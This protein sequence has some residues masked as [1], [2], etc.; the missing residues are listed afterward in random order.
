MRGGSVDRDF[1]VL[2]CICPYFDLIWWWLYTDQ[3]IPG[4][5][6]LHGCIAS[7]YT[8]GLINALNHPLG[9]RE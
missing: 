4:W 5:I 7:I 9:P 3:V 1:N 6:H 2:Q 8:D